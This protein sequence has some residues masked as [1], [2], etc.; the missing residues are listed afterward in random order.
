MFSTEHLNSLVRDVMAQLS[1]GAGDKNNNK[2]NHISSGE[3]KISITPSQ[4][5]VIAGFLAGVLDVSSVLVDR[6][7]TVEIVISGSLKQKTQMDKLLEQVG[8]K[9]F[10][11]VLKAIVGRFS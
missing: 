2:K 6:H 7:Q 3:Q 9:P 10:D 1:G 11:E 4:A 8:D 5:L